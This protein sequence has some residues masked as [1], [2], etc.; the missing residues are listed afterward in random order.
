MFFYPVQLTQDNETGAYVATCRD[1]P[2]FN[3]VGDTIEDAL[4]ECVDGLR[5]AI[6]IEIDERRPVPAGTLPQAGEHQVSVPILVAL[7]AALHNAMIETG[8]RKADL[9]RSM[10]LKPMQ[11]D[12]L[13]DVFHSSKVEAIELALA[14]LHR[15]VDLTVTAIA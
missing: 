1:L 12:R 9:C 4:I 11:I 6:S 13:L 2:L 8:W 7:K 15:R 5:A 3:S 10:G 14:Q